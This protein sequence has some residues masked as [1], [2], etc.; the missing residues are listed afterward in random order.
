MDADLIV[1][2]SRRRTRVGRRLFGVTRELLTYAICPV[3]AIPFDTVGV[4][5][6]EREAA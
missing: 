3:L 4:R 5:R 2:G 6:L 1:I